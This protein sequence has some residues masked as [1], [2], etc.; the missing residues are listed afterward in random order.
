M[1]SSGA[2]RSLAA[3]LG[4][5]AA[6][7]CVL[8]AE[9]DVARFR[10]AVPG[11]EA[12]ALSGPESRTQTSGTQSAVPSSSLQAED[13]PASDQW[14]EWYAFTRQVRDG[15][16][17]V[18]G[19]VL[20]GVWYIVH[21]RPTSIGDDEAVWGPH[22]DPLEP[23]TWRFRVREV[24]ENEYEYVLEGRP[25]TSTAEA[26]YRTVLRGTGYG[27][28][29][30]RHGDGSFLVDLDAARQLD[31]LKHRDDSGTV[32]V[33]HDLPRTIT[34]DV[35]AVPR[36][37][38]AELRPSAS[39]DWIVITSTTNEDFTGSIVVNGFVDI[40]ES[41]L[42]KREDVLIESRWDGTGAGRADITIAGGD[43]DPSYDPVN[44]T[45]CWG[46]D[47]SRVHYSDSAG[48]EAAYGDA[49]SCAY[50]APLSG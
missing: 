25:K 10:E 3:L 13:A 24:A 33:E 1:L 42:T 19:S 39:P 12:V 7:A 32:T 40:D 28:R 5:L 9:N 14:A 11:R 15:V 47:F 8:Q 2:A 30:A 34:T 41:K 38:T 50:D 22:T 27:K 23:A 35:F 37:I 46:A 44:A 21:T 43:L 48:F 4:A 31:P 20:G 16:N 45:E 49:A 18:T 29:D 26:D 36:V 17:A 6:P